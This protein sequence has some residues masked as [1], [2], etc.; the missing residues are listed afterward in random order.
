[1]RR[2]VHTAA[3][4]SA[5]ALTACTPTASHER[6]RPPAAPA[7]HGVVSG[8]VVQAGAQPRYTVEPG[9]SYDQPVALPDN[10]A[11]VYP[12][13]LLVRALPPVSVT[14]NLRVDADGRVS[15]LAPLAAADPAPA[16]FQASVRDAV[17]QWKFFPLVRIGP[18]GAPTV[19]T[20][21]DVATTYPGQVT[22]LP[23]SQTYRFVFSQVGGKPQVD[24][25][26]SDPVP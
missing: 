16:P 24:A 8:E 17:L 6:V 26:G 22:R 23:F 19:V 18:G 1:M 25:A 3:L 7:A 21:G 14:V 12:P 13:A 10:P 11:P 9:V 2:L 5:F 20:V 4:T 15:D